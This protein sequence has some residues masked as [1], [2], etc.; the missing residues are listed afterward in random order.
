LLLF[1]LVIGADGFA[2]NARYAFNLAMA[3]ARLQ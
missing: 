2:I 3:I 1:A